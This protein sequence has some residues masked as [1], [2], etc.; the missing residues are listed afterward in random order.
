MHALGDAPLA[1]RASSS[2]TTTLSSLAYPPDSG[3]FDA[4]RGN[5][6]LIKDLRTWVRTSLRSRLGCICVVQGPPGVGKST[7][8]RLAA[9]ENRSQLKCFN[10]SEMRTRDAVAQ[11]LN[12]LAFRVSAT[13]G[14]AF[15][16]HMSRPVL[17]VLEEVD[18]CSPEGFAGLTE[19]FREIT[20]GR[21][22]QMDDMS[23]QTQKSL[24]NPIICVGND[25]SKLKRFASFGRTFRFA[26]LPLD[27]LAAVASRA[28]FLNVPRAL[29]GGAGGDARSLLQTLQWHTPSGGTS[30]TIGDT[31]GS[32]VARK[33]MA[34]QT[35]QAVGSQWA[36]SM[37]ASFLGAATVGEHASLMAQ[38]ADTFV[39]ATIAE[40]AKYTMPSPMAM[41][42]L[43]LGHVWLP[44]SVSKL[45]APYGPNGDPAPLVLPIRGGAVGGGLQ[46]QRAQQ[47]VLASPHTFPRS[48]SHATSEL[49]PFCEAAKMAETTAYGEPG[50]LR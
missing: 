6:T 3:G 16:A 41:P 36:D 4:L 35:T 23:T 37:H 5:Q 19:L 12:D 22:V 32:D 47:L 28:G 25:W 24:S 11:H 1:H 21:Q 34:L 10:M 31:T 45:A 40:N 30:A 15:F 44:P 17:I 26:P 39:N 43:L 14:H 48:I 38:V 18:G 2:S 29:L 49:L 42:L 33:I 8:I 9:A 7:S 46:R 20:Q 50:S 13:A 27:D